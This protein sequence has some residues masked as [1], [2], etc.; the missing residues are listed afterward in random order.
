MTKSKPATKRV[1]PVILFVNLTHTLFGIKTLVLCNHGAIGGIPNP[2]IGESPP[3][4]LTIGGIVP[5]GPPTNPPCD[6]K[7]NCGP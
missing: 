7:G 3:L 2:P 1:I 6:V 4:E 5:K